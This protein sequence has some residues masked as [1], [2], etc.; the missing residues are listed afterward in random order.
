[1]N[2]LHPI[3]LSIL[4]PALV[5]GLLVLATHVPLGQEVLKRGIIFLDLAIAQMAGLGIVLAHFFGMEESGLSMQVAA[6]TAA[7]AGA[8]FLRWQEQRN[9]DTQEAVIGV[10]FVVAACLAILLMSHDPQ[11]GE[12][13]K[14]ILVGQI[15]WTTW[16][17]LLPLGILTGMV[18]AAWFGINA[19]R[20]SPWCFYPLF[21]IAITASVQIVGVYLVFASLIIPA[22]TMGKRLAVGWMIGSVGYALG[23]LASALFDLPSGA[24]IV[25]ALVLSGVSAGLIKQTRQ[26]H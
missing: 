10:A 12:H 17:D 1:M 4:A 23:L 5:A 26:T 15:L 6:V 8:L 18:L 20:A 3:D 14:D 16:S 7:L 9:P 21:A 11:A 25:L 13:L 22:L 2:L 24:A 19:V